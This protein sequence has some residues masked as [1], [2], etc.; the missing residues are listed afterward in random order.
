MI[1]PARR[2]VHTAWIASGASLVGAVR[3]VSIALIAMLAILAGPGIA[4]ASAAPAATAAWSITLAAQPTN[5]AVSAYEKGEVKDQYAIVL[6][7]TGGAA[8]GGPVTLTDT[9]PAGI[10]VASGDQPTGTGW[11]CAIAEDRTALTCIYPE[12]V[13]AFAQ[14]PPL[15]IPLAVAKTGSLTNTV[16]VSSP[17]TPLVTAQ[18]TTHVTG[19][20]SPI[21]S[22]ELLDF[23]SQAT[24]LSGLPDS[25]AGDHP[26]SITT[27]L[28]FPEIESETG[29]ELVV[30]HPKAIEVELPPGFVGNPQAAAKCMLVQLV[31]RQCPSSSRVG[32]SYINLGQG[33]FEAEPSFQLYNIVPEHGYPAEFGLYDPHIEKLTILYATIG[34]APAYR[35]R[36]VIPDVPESVSIAGAITTFFGDPAAADQTGGVHTPLLTNPAHCDGRPL[37]TNVR[38][39]SWE[40]PERWVTAQYE[41]PAVTGCNL[42]QFHPSFTLTP[43]TSTADEPTGAS[44]ELKVPQAPNSGLEGLATPPVKSTLVTLPAGLTLNPAAAQGLTGCP[45]EGPGG[46][47]LDQSGAGHC[48]LGSQIG[49]AEAQT[50]LLT[51]A[52]KGHLYV[53]EPQCGG[54]SQPVCGPADALDGKLF[55]LDLQLE[56]SGVTVKLHG[57]TA[58]NPTTGQ[59]TV[60]FTEAPQDPVSDLQLTL[61]GGTRAPLAT[62]QS[63][64]TATGSADIIPWSSPETP[65]ATSTFAFNVT[66]CE[67]VVFN[68]GFSAGTTSTV[69]GAYTTLTTTFT[70][71]ARTQD[72]AGVQVKTPTGLLGMLSHVALCPEPQA[73]Q[74][75]CDASSRIGTANTAAGAGST[76]QWVSGPVYLTGP[77]NGAPFGLSVAV[78]AAAGPFNLGTIVVRAA[79]NIDPDTSAITVTSSP[80]PQII[81]GVPLRIQTVNVT[82]DRPQFIFNPTGCTR[83][84]IDATITSAQ[85]SSANA[86]TPFQPSGCSQLPFRP[87]FAAS[88]AAGTSK[89]NGASLS[90]KITSAAGQANIGRVD[91]Q[92][93]K[94]LPSRLS[95]LQQACTE[96][97]FAA[98]PAGCPAGA[99]IGWAK[100][101]TPVL[102]VALMGPAYLVSHGGA[103]FPDV[104]F[105]LQGQGIRI[106]VDGNTQIKKG[107]TYSHFETVPDAPITSFETVLPRGPHSILGA[108]LPAKDNNSLCGV[109]LTI[110][111]TLTGQNGA[112][113]KQNTKLTVTGCPHKNAKTSRH[114][115]HNNHRPTH[116]SHNSP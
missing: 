67:P 77:Y 34:P 91:V 49:T 46:F 103:A 88:T 94:Q 65:D 57:V 14:T 35:T 111:T 45:A 30:Q 1:V 56:G 12:P 72:L 66:G 89:L 64:G 86:A 93:P 18:R 60:T 47:N 15:T 76:P 83:R 55:G 69:P 107:I 62:P 95:T 113:I 78:P 51:E 28:D 104:V 11:N 23:S 70:R 58:A 82:I 36:V 96:R 73:A 16:S 4:A 41:A 106:D 40:E 54:A 102:N 71:G 81:D 85:G 2:P 6:T 22:Y 75:S 19:S 99:V 44:V 105:V 43:E 114:N 24:G 13:Q 20:T 9:L 50:P 52:L 74:G 3:T 37:V 53:A 97:Q 26:F 38:S 39:D 100:A 32:G 108:Y 27:A 29:P 90:V 7:N 115:R 92:L 112:V 110:P 61:K 109:A 31:S 33:L 21:P 10:T 63:C 116:T 42:L 17:E 101:I 48:P 87:T 80:L 68:P 5:L 98:N 25:Q 59:L 8:S 84:S 79:I